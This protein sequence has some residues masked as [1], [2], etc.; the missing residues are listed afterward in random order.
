MQPAICR[1]KIPPTSGSTPGRSEGEISPHHSRDRKLK[2][3]LRCTGAASYYSEKC[4]RRQQSYSIGTRLL[5]STSTALLKGTITGSSTAVAVVVPPQQQVQHPLPCISTRERQRPAV[6]EA[7]TNPPL[8]AAATAHH[9]GGRSSR[10]P[11]PVCSLPLKCQAHSSRCCCHAHCHTAL[12]GPS[13][14][15][16]NRERSINPK[17]NTLHWQLVAL[18]TTGLACR[19]IAVLLIIAHRQQHLRRRHSLDRRKAAYNARLEPLVPCLRLH[20][21]FCV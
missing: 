20:G 21:G 18:G 5:T 19:R 2:C 11:S 9:N 10:A 13:L 6:Q 17:V 16:Q 7:Q 1:C 8:P 14:E 4:G 15:F 12:T 3:S